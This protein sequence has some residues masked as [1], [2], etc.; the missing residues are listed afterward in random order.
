MKSKKIYTY[1][2]YVIILLY[3]VIAAYNIYSKTYLE[4]VQNIGLIFVFVC[5]LKVNQRVNK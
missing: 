3:A 2:L 1:L 5:I 4:M